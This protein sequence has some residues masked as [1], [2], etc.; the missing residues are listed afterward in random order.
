V[1]S[2]DQEDRLPMELAAE[3]LQ[4]ALAKVPFMPGVPTQA[5]REL[6]VRHFIA[7]FDKEP[8]WW[9]GE[10]MFEMAPE[11]GTAEIV[12]VIAQWLA[13]QDPKKGGGDERRIHAAIRALAEITGLDLRKTPAENGPGVDRPL[14]EVIADYV[15]ECG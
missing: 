2:S 14:E 10:R 1:G 9:V 12:P 5:D 7:T 4:S 6:F 15:R 13:H 11:L 3:P 8:F